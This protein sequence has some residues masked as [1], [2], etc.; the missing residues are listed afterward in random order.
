MVSISG[1]SSVFCIKYVEAIF[2]F[3]LSIAASSNKIVS[4]TFLYF[5][6]MEQ[7][8]SASTNS[9]VKFPFFRKVKFCLVLK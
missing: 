6:E 4:P 9:T 2:E 3:V 8:K 5:P 1:T 7:M